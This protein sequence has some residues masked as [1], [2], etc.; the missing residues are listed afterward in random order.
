MITEKLNN[1]KSV[2]KSCTI[3]RNITKLVY[4]NLLGNQ[5]NL[6]GRNHLR[7]MTKAFSLEAN[8]SGSFEIKISKD[9][10][11][12]CSS[13][14]SDFVLNVHLMYMEVINLGLF[15]CEDEN[16]KIKCMS[17]D[18]DFC[19]EAVKSGVSMNKMHH[20]KDY[21]HNCGKMKTRLIKS[22]IIN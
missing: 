12:K 18:F 13:E 6:I 7:K 8:K 2:Y 10:L 9:Y 16:E 1:K 15:S 17:V 4:N 20:C 21:E 19:N 22:G 3:L 5:H 14:M 11:K